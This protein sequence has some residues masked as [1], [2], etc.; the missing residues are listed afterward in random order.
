MTFGEYCLE[1]SQICIK[2][3]TVKRLEKFKFI[4]E[5]YAWLLGQTFKYLLRKND[6]FEKI[7]QSK[8]KE[9]KIDFNYPIVGY[10]KNY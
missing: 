10:K 9:L 7:L 5:P 1:S 3:N 2:P 4:N 6:N 8:I